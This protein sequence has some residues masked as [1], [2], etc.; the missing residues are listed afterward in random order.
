MEVSR[1]TASIDKYTGLSSEVTI[2]SPFNGSGSLSGVSVFAPQST[3]LPFGTA[4]L[5]GLPTQLGID[6]KSVYLLDSANYND[7]VILNGGVRYDDY[8]IST[9]GYGTVNGAPNV[10][11]AQ[12]AEFGLPNFNLGL[13]LKPL[14]IASVYAA[15]AT[16]SNPVGAEFDGTSAALWRARANAQRCSKPNLRP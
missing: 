1:E 8:N 3:F 14:P 6:T 7:L 9:S 15:Y 4:A 10:F 5:S 16:S 12:S 2:G 13:V 11:G